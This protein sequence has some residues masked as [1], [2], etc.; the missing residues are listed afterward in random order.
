M[1]DKGTNGTES[2]LVDRSSIG[3]LGESLNTIKVCYWNIHGW[4]S[5]IIG[6]KLCDEE[7]LEN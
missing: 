3:D 6:D 1:V 2:Y 5:K 7:F 4:S